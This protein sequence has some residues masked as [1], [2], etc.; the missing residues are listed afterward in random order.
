MLTADEFKAILRILRPQHPGRYHTKEQLEIL[1]RN[2]LLTKALA[3]HARL[4]KI[5]QKPAIQYRIESLLRD[6]LIKA[7]VDGEIHLRDITDQDV[8][9]YYAVHR[10][11]FVIPETISVHQIFIAKRVGTVEQ[12]QSAELAR[13]VAHK[14]KSK[15]GHGLREFQELVRTHSEDKISRSRGGLIG[16]FRG[17]E[18][19][20]QPL[21]SIQRIL[22]DEASK[23]KNIG[24]VAGPIETPKGYHILRLSARRS[25]HVRTLNQVRE[26]LRYQ[27]YKDHRKAALQRLKDSA[28]PATSIQVD[29][30][31]VENFLARGTTAESPTRGHP[32][33]PPIPGIPKSFEAPMA[34]KTKKGATA[35]DAH[36]PTIDNPDSD[37]KTK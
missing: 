16:F 28:L 9:S 4:Q 30:A 12:V 36:R 27:L 17:D 25:E 24:D 14:A 3:N 7:K 13:D 15:G 32:P 22:R 34:Q 33:V 26:E 8:A 18:L 37:L 29:L 31:A 5:H 10:E 20:G 23:L 1:A 6:E 21:N 11:N 19:D 35:G 2:I